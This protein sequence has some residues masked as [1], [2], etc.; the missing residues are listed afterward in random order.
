MRK[1]SPDAVA[2]PLPREF[3]A[4]KTIQVARDLLGRIVVRRLGR[5]LLAGRI[6][7]TEAYLGS[8]DPA[9]HAARRQTPRNAVMFGPPGHAYVYFTYGMHFCFNAVAH[10]GLAG[11]VLIRA[12]EPLA[13]LEEMERRRGAPDRR[14]LTNGPA[15]LCQA[16]GIGRPEN[17]LPLFAGAL[18]VVDAPGVS[19][20]R[21]VARP[22]VGIRAGADL[23]YR[24]YE[25][26]NPF[27]SKP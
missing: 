6:V 14:Q 24:F 18:Q 22:R 27:V 7:E 5:T 25:R 9:S 3:Y 23:L 10:D 12:L 13:G 19:R 16:L 1:T 20:R 2:A 8:D 17:R 26:D 4:R 15:K 11:A 21:I